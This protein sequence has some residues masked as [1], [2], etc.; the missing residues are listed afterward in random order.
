MESTTKMQQFIPK[1][2]PEESLEEGVE[3]ILRT[4]RFL[5]DSGVVSMNDL[6]LPGASRHLVVR[7]RDGALVAKSYA[8]AV[9]WRAERDNLEKF[10][11]IVDSR[12]AIF[13]EVTQSDLPYIQLPTMHES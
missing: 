4:M 6:V 10:A 7:S 12:S 8:D 9:R 2:F 11:Y 5:S 13:R 3:R 1:P